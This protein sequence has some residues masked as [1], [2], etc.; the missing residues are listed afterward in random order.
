MAVVFSFSGSRFFIGQPVAF[1]Q[2]NLILTDFA[3]QIWNEVLGIESIGEFGDNAAYGTFTSLGDRRQTKFLTHFEGGD[4]QITMA[5][6]AADAGQAALL[7]AGNDPGTN[8]AIKI[9]YD[10]APP[11]GTPSADL[12]IALIGPMRRAGGSNT[13]ALKWM[14]SLGVNSNLVQVYPVTGATAPNNTALPAITG[15]ARVGVALSL[16]NGTWTGTP[17]PTFTYQWFAN[18]ESIPG[19]TA[20]AFTPVVGNIGQTITGMVRAHN[21]V[22]IAFAMSAATSAVIAA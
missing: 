8:Y 21:S 10:D 6:N 19:A 3:G 9:E 4:L 7:A 16:S 13:D 12:F 20:S 15:T 22:G 18:G 14:S 5:R 2:S 11:G 17:T 1:K